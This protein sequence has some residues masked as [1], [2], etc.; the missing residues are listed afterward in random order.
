MLLEKEDVSEVQGCWRNEFGM[1]TPKCILVDWLCVEFGADVTVLNLDKEHSE[2]L[3][4][5]LTVGVFRQC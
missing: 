4:V 1:P 3:T 2:D 5:Q